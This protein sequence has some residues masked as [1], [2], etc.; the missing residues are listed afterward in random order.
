MHATPLLGLD[1]L[2]T[3]L[4]RDI[5]ALCSLVRSSMRYEATI[6]YDGELFCW[7]AYE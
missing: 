4:I 5:K 6:L 7:H 2:L 1:A 3:C